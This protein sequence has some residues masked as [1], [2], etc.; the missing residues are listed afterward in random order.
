[1]CEIWCILVVRVAPF[2]SRLRR[3]LLLLLFFLL[4]LDQ[5]PSVVVVAGLYGQ[6]RSLPGDHSTSLIE[7]KYQPAALKCLNLCAFFFNEQPC[8]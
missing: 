5:I 4:S 7:P 2:V 1:M 6:W 8:P 3:E